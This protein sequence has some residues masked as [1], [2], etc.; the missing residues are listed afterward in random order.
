MITRYCVIACRTCAL[1]CHRSFPRWSPDM[2]TS[3]PLMPSTSSLLYILQSTVSAYVGLSLFG[4]LLL[5]LYVYLYVCL[6][7]CMSVCMSVCVSVCMSTFVCLSTCPH[8]PH[9]TR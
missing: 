4:F 7:V 1:F 6:S 5:C 2:L 8:L 3:F 9:Q